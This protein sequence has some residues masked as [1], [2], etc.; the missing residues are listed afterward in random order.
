MNALRAS[1]LLLACVPAMAGASLEP[2][3]RR[4]YVFAVDKTGAPVVDLTAA[5]FT[6]KENGKERPILSVGPATGLI[7]VAILVDDNGTGLFRVGVARFIESLLSRAEFSISTVTGQ[8]LRLVDYTSNAQSLSEAIAKLNARPA[9]NDG[10]QLLDGIS[11]T[12]VELE[13]REARRPVIVALTVG[14]QE[15]STLPAH[16][17]L[18]N[19]RKSGASLHVLTVVN[20]TLRS[21]PTATSAASLL[22]ENMNLGEVLGDG[23]KQSGGGTDEI[24]AA[25]SVLTGLQQLAEALKR[26][27][28][29]EYSLP[30]GVKPS[31]KLNVSVKRRGVT[32]RAPTRIPDK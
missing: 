21:Q 27:Y 9:T 3:I 29:I 5:D 22:G 28:V 8:M 13:R 7:Q 31:G 24:V 12:A 25:A 1:L 17:V 30:D 10:G 4:V 16:H 26:Q 6:L 2:Q 15:H 18:D 14:G 19:L 23:P 11:E 32:L 20:N